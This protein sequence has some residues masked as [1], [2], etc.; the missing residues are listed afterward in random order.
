[1]ETNAV[2][3]FIDSVRSYL[4]GREI[5][6]RV[7]NQTYSMDPAMIGLWIA[8]LHH[9]HFKTVQRPRTLKRNAEALV[10]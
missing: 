2:I 3:Y 7:D 5:T 8:R 1:M 4:A 9:Y 10:K 6:L